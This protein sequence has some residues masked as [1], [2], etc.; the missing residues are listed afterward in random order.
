[1]LDARNIYRKVTRKIY[2]F[3]PEQLQNI[4]AIIWLYRGE[5]SRFVELVQSYIDQTLAEAEQSLAPLEKFHKA[6]A[7]L[8]DAMAPFLKSL[9]DNGIH[10]ENH[11]ELKTALNDVKDSINAFERTKTKAGKQWREGRYVN[12]PELSRFIESGQALAALA[13]QSRDMIKLLDHGFKT[14]VRLIDFCEKDLN[15]KVSDFWNATEIN[16]SRKNTLKKQA[17]ATRKEAV[18]KVRQVRYFYKQV[19]WLLSRFPEG[20]LTDVEGLVKLVSL[21]DLEA[22]DWSLTPGRYVGVAPE[23]VDEDFDFEEALRD[24]HTELAG[25]NE[26]AVRLAGQIATNFEGLAI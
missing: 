13:E 16:G 5:S 3:T 15:A 7:D 25:L 8:F 18:D 12:A 4:T 24:I 26:E 10:S 6:M 17:E 2:D 22:N 23:A 20:K 11:D 9:P 14:M 1:M 19:L 21:K